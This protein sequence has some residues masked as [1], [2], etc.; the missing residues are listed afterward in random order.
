MVMDKSPLYVQVMNYL[1][2]KIEK[3]YKPGDLIPTQA[4]LAE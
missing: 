3:E 1:L 2:E 4:E